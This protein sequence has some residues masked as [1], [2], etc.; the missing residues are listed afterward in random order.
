MTQLDLPPISI[1]RYVDLLKRR[2]W[3][4]V[5]ISLLGLVV[6]A[7]VAFF[8]P[9][10]YV[11]FTDLNFNIA[12]LL[13]RDSNVVQDPLAEQISNAKLLI[14]T[15]VPRTLEKLGWPEALAS[16][17]S[18][19]WAFHAAVRDRIEI[20][21][22]DLSTKGR[23]HTNL[24]ISY[25]DRDARRAADFANALRDTWVAEL[26]GRMRDDTL[27]LREIEA[28]NR[29]QQEEALDSIRQEM[30]QFAERNSFDPTTG[31]VREGQLS[32]SAEIAERERS[33]A[34]L[35]GRK[36]QAE[37]ALGTLRQQDRE[38][39]VQKMITKPVIPDFTKM[40]LGVPERVAQLM[41][42]VR[43]A[44][45]QLNSMTKQHPSYEVTIRQRD[46]AR[47]E[48]QRYLPAETVE[49]VPNPAYL[50]LQKKIDDGQ[51][52]LDVMAAEQEHLEKRLEQL[53]LKLAEVPALWKEWSRRRTDEE[54]AVRRLEEMR[55]NV[56]RVNERLIQLEKLQ[57]FRVI[58]P[59]FVPA[60]PTEPNIVLL[61]L[62]GSL[63]GL[64]LAIG[65]ILLLD[66]LRFTFKTLEEVERALPVPLL[67]GVSHLETSEERRATKRGRMTLIVTA[68]TALVLIL[69]V[70]TIYYVAPAR[71]PHFV[72]DLLEV[73]LGAE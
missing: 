9:R 30:Q 65:V 58:N 20:N 21:P 46:S 12:G 4:V 23:V 53:R 54:A 6:G 62:V 50:E 41:A 16:D 57:P 19:R 25:K 69:A 71:L 48:L 56:D 63:V 73:V 26:I 11:T 61:A 34:N 51:A 32:L 31:S 27:H 60:R 33:L 35:V 17:F 3:Q 45:L 47:A 14:P 64:A 13:P 72:R 29:E 66:T 28:N 42:T 36:R 18:E 22:S 55:A 70:V 67:G 15:V 49:T 24:R 44:E 7:L 38:G 1:A 8:I 37:A 68:A 10:Y 40:G 52:E 5:P 39:L 59:A 2:R 43:Y